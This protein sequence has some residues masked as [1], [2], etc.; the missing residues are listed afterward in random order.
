MI[1][2]AITRPRRQCLIEDV[3]TRGQQLDRIEFVHVR[4]ELDALVAHRK[5]DISAFSFSLLTFLTA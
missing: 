1:V 3:S 4:L 2:S 5:H